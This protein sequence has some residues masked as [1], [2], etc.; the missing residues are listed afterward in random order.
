MPQTINEYLFPWNMYKRISI[1]NV[2]INF[3]CQI[4]RPAQLSKFSKV[5]HQILSLFTIRTAIAIQKLDRNSTILEMS[6]E[7]QLL[8]TTFLK[9]PMCAQLEAQIGMDRCSRTIV[10]RNVG[11]NFEIHSAFCAPRKWIKLEARP[12]RGSARNWSAIDK[13]RSRMK[14]S[15]V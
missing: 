8:S 11:G 3:P 5:N 4:V 13:E 10:S 2:N 14:S 6:I 9:N 12:R 7:L 15:I 1:S